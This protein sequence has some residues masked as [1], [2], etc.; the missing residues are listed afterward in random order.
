MSSINSLTSAQLVWGVRVIAMR[1]IAAYFDSSIAYVY[2]IAFVVLANSLFMNE[3]FLTG[4]VDMSG[5]FHMLPLL[6]VVFLPA[7]TMRLWAEERKSRT[8]ELLLTLPIKP[9]QAVVGKFLAA[10]ALFLLFLIGS[11]TIPIMLASLGDP[12]FGLIFAGYLG[13]ILFGGMFLAFGMLLSALSGDQIVAFI[14]SVLV[15]AAFV[16]S[17]DDRV[18]AVI[19]GMFP[20]ASIGTLL[21]EHFSV[22][23]HY[24]GF[25]R[26]VVALPSLLYF[27]LLTC[28]FLWLNAAV[29]ERI[30]G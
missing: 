17:G 24:E 10:M 25:V 12:D 26:G 13:L 4:T 15:G 8:I 29:L 14:I 21:Y 18:V 11:L 2:S 3:F 1:E 5:F 6:L 9:V 27:G 23:P 28:V 22:L 30:R 19:D 7:V 16:L 20:A